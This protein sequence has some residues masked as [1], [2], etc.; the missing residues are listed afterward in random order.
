MSLPSKGLVRRLAGGAFIAMLM[1]SAATAALAAPA[2]DAK[3]DAM[4]RQLD[5]MRA[6]IEL[7]RGGGT[8]DPRVAAMQEQLDS[9]AKQ[10]AEMQAAQTTAASD[11]AT[12]RTPTGS[13]VV[14]TLSNGRP[15]FTTAD[16]RFSAQ[17]R[18]V[19]MFDAGKYFQDENLP[20]ATVGRDL[21]DGTNFR[22]ARFG[23]DGKLYGDFDYS[24]IYEF[25]GSGAE[26]AGHIQEAWLQYTGFKPVRIRLGAFEANAGLAAA[27][28]TSGMP[29]MERPAPAEVARSVA[30]GDFRSGLQIAAN[31]AFGEGDTG[32]STRWFVSGALTGNTV[33]VVGS[34]GSGQAQPFDEQTGLVGRIALAPFAGTD[35]QAHFGVNALHSLQPN[36]AGGAA[37][38]RYA[39]QLRDRPELR[40]DA[41]R[42][43]DTGAIDADHVTVYG[44]EAAFGFRNVLVEGEAFRYGI[45]RRLATAARPNDP[46]FSGWYVQGSWVLTGEPRLYDPAEARFAAPKQTYNFN[47]AAGTW[48]AF[49]V[50]ARYSVLDLNHM[51]GL[52][53]T[54]AGVSTVRGG[55]Q[56]IASFG[57]NWYVNPAVR[58]MLNWQ[59]VDVDRMNAAGAQIGQSY[60]ALALR[61]QLTF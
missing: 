28:S 21:N 26:D 29:L 30:A 19:V 50:A 14:T 22:R 4:Q 44:A 31:G 13:A 1:T 12:L 42:L 46:E 2:R 16:K 39:A 45:D 17:L 7:L 52:P 24:L 59:H 15:A 5:E 9:F 57:L 18:A 35:W 49:E 60:N 51:E 40:L 54:A 55:E 56:K 33:G 8:A 58:F 10:L 41:T 61:S 37:N 47:P 20:A 48:G 34:T 36:D 3:I 25:G 38:P 11:I 23:V 27:T 43:V 53:G 32:L 6:Q